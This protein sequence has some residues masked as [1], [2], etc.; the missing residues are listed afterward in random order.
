MHISRRFYSHWDHIIAGHDALAIDPKGNTNPLR[1][2]FKHGRP[3][4]TTGWQELVDFYSLTRESLFHFTYN[5]PLT[6]R[7]RIF[8]NDG[9]EIAYPD[10]GNGPE[11]INLDSDDES[12]AEVHDEVQVMQNEPVITWEKV[13]IDRI[14]RGRNPLVRPSHSFNLSFLL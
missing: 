6:F 13:V 2:A 12:Q 10:N 11:V 4:F 9:T 5:E 14:A 3:A 8:A 1:V 7:I